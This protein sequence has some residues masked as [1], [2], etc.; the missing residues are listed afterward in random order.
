MDGAHIR[1]LQRAL[2]IVVTKERLAAALDVRLD[3]LDSYFTGKEPLPHQA[4]LTALDIVS[5]GP[6]GPARKKAFDQK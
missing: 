4:F 5:S 3:E 1:T 2:E 6:H